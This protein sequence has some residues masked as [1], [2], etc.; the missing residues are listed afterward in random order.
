MLLV[1]DCTALGATDDP[2]AA[3]RGCGRRLRQFCH[4]SDGGTVVRSPSSPA[5]MDGTGQGQLS[6]Q[7]GLGR[8]AESSASV[9]RDV[10]G[11]AA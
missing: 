5:A 1:A 10:V 4:R 9:P 2:W 8:A 7:G 3:S 11:G 6:A